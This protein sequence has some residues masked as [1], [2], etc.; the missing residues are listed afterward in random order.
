MACPEVTTGDVIVPG[1][2]YGRI[3]AAVDQGQNVWRL[4]PV[5]TAQVIG[6]EFL[7]LRPTDTYTLVEQ[8]YDRGSGLAHA[9]VRV[10]HGE[11]TYLVEL[12]QP[13]KQGPGGIWVVQSVTEL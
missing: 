9:V 8:Y 5:R 6:S 11:C 3:Q 7:G 10:R 2:N 13:R 4:I 12:F 1:E